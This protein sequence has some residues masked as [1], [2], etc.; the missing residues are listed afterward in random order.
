MKIVRLFLLVFV[1]AGCA[2]AAP[3]ISEFMAS[4]DSTLA[5]E[6]GDYPDWIEIYNPDAQAVD[7]AGWH[8]TDDASELNQWTFPSVSIPAGGYLVVFASKKNRATSGQPLH[9]NFKLKTGGEY[10]ALVQPDGVTVATEYDPY[11][12]QQTDVSYGQPQGTMVTENV[13]PASAP[14]R[15]LVP[16]EPVTGWQSVAFDDSAWSA[17]T[18]GIG[19][20]R[21]ASNSYGPFIHTDIESET[22]GVNGSVYLRIEFQVDDPTQVTAL[23]LRTRHDDGF[24]AWINGQSVANDNISAFATWNSTA[25]TSQEADLQTPRVWDATALIPHLVAGK[26]VLA[27]QLVNQSTTSSDFLFSAG[28]HLTRQADP[29]VGDRY[30]VEP[31][32]GAENNTA[33]G[34]PSEP[35]KVSEPSGVKT[36]AVSVTLS[37]EDPAADIRYT[38]DGTEP[39]ES[40]PRYTGPLNLSDPAR[41]RARAYAPGKVAGPVAVADYAFIDASLTSYLAN[42]PVVVMDNFGAGSYPNKGSSSDGRG[43]VQVPRQP[44]VVS[45]FGVPGNSQP[46]TQPAS[47]ET[48][49]GCR[50]RGASSSGFS[51]KSL[52]VEFWDDK[53]NDRSLSPLGM[54]SEADWVLYAPAPDYDKSLLHNPVSFGFASMVGALAPNSKVVVVFQNKDGGKITTAD[55]V[56]VYV[57]ME[58]IERNRMG[59]DFDKLDETGTSGGWMVSVDR[60][61]AIPVGMPSNTVQPNF[62]A[63][64]PDGILSIPD[65]AYGDSSPQTEDDISRYYHSFLNFASPDGYS[66]LPDQRARVQNDVRAMDAAVWSASSTDPETGYA[67]H[68]DP[69][70]WARYYLVQNFAHNQDAVVLSTYLYKPSAEEKIKMGPV[71]DFDRAYTWSG[72]ATNSPL[73]ASDRDWFAGLFADVDFKQK[74]QDI[75]Q[76]ARATTASDSALEAL[77]NEN[78]AGLR[79]DQISASG[80]DYWTWYY[81]VSSMLTWM[82]DRA[83]FLDSQ[84]EP[85]PTVTPETELFSGSITVSMVPDPGITVYFTTDGSDPRAPGGAVATTATAYTA[86]VVISTRTRIIARAK[87]GVEWSAPVE[88]NYYREADVPQLVVSEIDYH[89]ADPTPGEEE[90]GYDDAD[91][92]EYLE[93]MNIGTG[94]A[95]LTSLELGGGIRYDF[96]ASAVSSLPPGGCVL[97]VRNLAAFEARHGSGLPVAGQYQGSLGNGG[98]RIVLRDFLLDM[99]LQDFSY[100]DD[101]PWPECA[102]GDGYSLVLTQPENNPDLSD[103]SNWR[104]SATTAGSP[105]GSDA[106]AHFSGTPKEDLDGDGIPA[107]VEHFLGTPD[108]DST[109]GPGRVSVSSIVHSDDGQSYPVMQV[110]YRIGA[111]DVDIDPLWSEDLESWSDAPADV[112]LESHTLHGDGTATIIWRGTRPISSGKQ[113]LRL[114]VRLNQ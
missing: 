39:R 63:A 91:D 64:G 43:V 54:D 52:S 42:V 19:Y 26:N 106:V 46:F 97:V 32:P 104:C 14:A 13:I 59:M 22:Y 9:T 114:R 15:Y 5:D 29:V 107:L 16:T 8:L 66:I 50:V 3:V 87:N 92:F 93:I 68:L 17:G 56:G 75:W 28:L 24:A 71:W 86:P 69:D 102:D 85:M 90:Q 89:P 70:S 44:N 41:L 72:S 100:S 95:D 31:T 73:W 112:V 61:K 105:G 94:T 55:M 30:F 20:D 109:E 83:H 27:V 21:D 48:R 74:Q 47:L 60:L 98:D 96:S 37:T 11:P 12:V 58:K 10:L 77:V 51:R 35:V 45:I 99:T 111:D 67:A 113:F 108:T 84:Y 33:P 2:G 40:S 103:A 78:A 88:R 65:D 18:N 7:I 6:D 76:K 53:D 57:W 25:L 82:L 79:A 49:A 23:E 80:L 34:E 101:D 62:H 110:Q 1:L 38:L 4:N 36:S 81:R